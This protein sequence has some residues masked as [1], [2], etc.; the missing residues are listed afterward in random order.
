LNIVAD[1]SKVTDP[2]NEDE[3]DDEGVRRDDG[4]PNPVE[5]GKRKKS[6]SQKSRCFKRP[7]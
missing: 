3:E 5:S 6:K 4:E 7:R 2:E 1:P